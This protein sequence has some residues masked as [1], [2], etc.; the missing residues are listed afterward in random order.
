[1][2]ALRDAHEAL[3]SD[4]RLLLVHPYGAENPV[5]GGGSRLGALDA[6][7]FADAVRVA[8]SAVDN[9]LFE[10]VDERRFEI[11]EHFDDAE[12]L[13]AEVAEWQRTVTP[14]ALAAAVRAAAPPFTV[15][16]PI[17]LRLY[18]RL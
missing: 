10:Q 17:V 2:H 6:R 3:V 8:E 14:P 12:T 16:L 5:A 4:G 13:L 9:T 1:V 18:H 7:E 11:V 15:C